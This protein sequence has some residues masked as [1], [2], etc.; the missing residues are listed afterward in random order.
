MKQGDAAAAY[1]ASHWT[2]WEPS[3]TDGAQHPTLAPGVYP[4]LDEA[5][6]TGGSSG[7]LWGG[8][9]VQIYRAPAVLDAGGAPRLRAVD[10]L[11]WLHD[12]GRQAV[13]GCVGLSSSPE[14]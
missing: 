10:I 2:A 5:D 6:A 3:G 1:C 11:Q 9:T 12:P 13:A 4:K 14:R 7:D 8:V